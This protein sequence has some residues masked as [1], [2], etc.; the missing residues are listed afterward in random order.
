MQIYTSKVH[1]SQS[2]LYNKISKK[3]IILPKIGAKRFAK[4]YNL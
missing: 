1:H 2:M 3:Y 4:K